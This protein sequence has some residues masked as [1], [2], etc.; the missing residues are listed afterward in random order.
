MKI[1]ARGT[2]ARGAV[3]ATYE[4]GLRDVGPCGRVLGQAILCARRTLAVERL[5]TP[6]P[7]QARRHWRRPHQWHSEHSPRRRRGDDDALLAREDGEE[8][9]AGSAAAAAAGD[10]ASADFAVKP[11]SRM[12]PTEHSLGAQCA[13][14]AAPSPAVVME[15]RVACHIAADPQPRLCISLGRHERR[16]AQ[17]QDRVERV[18]GW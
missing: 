6:E 12:W 8:V 9:V 15:R 14:V 10:G 17:P 4:V 16:R 7:A 13:C 2:V 18:R 5:L 1:E 3:A 11:H